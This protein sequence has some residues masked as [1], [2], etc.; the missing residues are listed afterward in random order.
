MKLILRKKHILKAIKAFKKKEKIDISKCC[1]MWQ[2]FHEKTKKVK[3]CVGRDVI[4][5][6]NVSLYDLKPVLPDEL[7]TSD[8]WDD[9]A[10]KAPYVFNLIKVK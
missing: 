6:D 10:L 3:F 7:Y 4:A 2:A 8:G 1:P 5:K 9:A